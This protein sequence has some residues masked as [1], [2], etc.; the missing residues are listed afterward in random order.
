M[1]NI[2]IYGVILGQIGLVLA[3]SSGFIGGSLASQTDSIYTVLFWRFLCASCILLPLT[4]VSLKRLTAQQWHNQ[5]SIGGLAMFGY[6][7]T[8]ISAIEMGISPAL[9]ALITALQPILTA[10]LSTVMLK[11]KL[12]LKQWLGLL[13]ALFGVMLPVIEQMSL[14]TGYLPIGLA[15]SS[16]VCIV[17]A[18]FISQKQ[19]LPVSVASSLTIQCLISCV[20]FLPLA[21]FDHGVSWEMSHSFLFSVSW[22]VV[23]STFCAYGLYWWVLSKTSANHVALLMYFT[24][25]CTSVWAWLMFDEPI[26][27]TVL[28][29]A[30]MI[31][32]GVLFAHRSS[33][34][35]SSQPISQQ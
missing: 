5:L 34:S 12:S 3:W 27:A 2:K 25:P 19:K 20:L 28:V 7:A 32:I 8:M 35:L 23:F 9:A 26:K 21:L 33:R 1:V 16:T 10:T 15:L 24:P 22:F 31:V 11:T 29:G 6:L 4:V 17:W 18:T 13:M 30:G 14:G